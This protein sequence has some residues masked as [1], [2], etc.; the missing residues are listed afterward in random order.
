M[1]K[2]PKTKFEA[3]GKLFTVIFKRKN[4]PVNVPVNVPKKRLTVILKNIESNKK[5][6]MIELANVLKVNKKT[7]KRDIKNMKKKDLIKRIG[8]DKGGY[9]E[10][11][12]K[13]KKS[14]K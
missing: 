8:P 2:E 11:I 12:K 13:S 4:V 9:W 10:I 1:S 14:G 6:T 3:F 7:I 5:I